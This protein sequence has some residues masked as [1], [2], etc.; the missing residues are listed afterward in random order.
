MAEI[1]TIGLDSGEK[2]VPDPWHWGWGARNLFA[3]SVKLKF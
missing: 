1:T 2:R 3:N